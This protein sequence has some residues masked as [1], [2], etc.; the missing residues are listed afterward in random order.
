MSVPDMK[1]LYADFHE[2]G[3]EIV[4]VTQYYGYIGDSRNLSEEE[5]FAAMADF[6]AEKEEPWP[7][8]FGDKSND[9]AYGIGLP[10]W[11]VLD[12]E[13]NVA[14]TQ[15]GYSAE[16]FVLFR[17]KI[18][19]LIEARSFVCRELAGRRRR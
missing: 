3:L 14:F 19:G 2:D 15:S 5:E 8:V 6:R 13:G 16:S 10:L 9:E 12:R 1:Q 17:E 11:V 4:A 18:K 7:M